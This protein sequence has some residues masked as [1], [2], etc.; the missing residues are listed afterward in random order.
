MSASLNKDFVDFLLS[1]DTVEK[2]S[3]EWLE[4]IAKLF[5]VIRLLVAFVLWHFLWAQDNEIK[6][7][8]D[9]IGA[10]STDFNLSTPFSRHWLVTCSCI[11]MLAR[12][13]CCCKAKLRAQGY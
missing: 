8:M 5:V 13:S 7:T 6:S 3:I 9:L 12:Y 4:A 1:V 11:L 2:R 10:V